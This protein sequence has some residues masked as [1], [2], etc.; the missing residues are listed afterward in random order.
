MLGY[1]KQIWGLS[2]YFEAISNDMLSMLS[3]SKDPSWRR[4]KKKEKDTVGWID[5]TIGA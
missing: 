3:W 5:G 1:L 4:E 2:I